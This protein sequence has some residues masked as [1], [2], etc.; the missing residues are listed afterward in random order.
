[1]NTCTAHDNLQSEQ[2]PK[3]N[4]YASITAKIVAA[5]EGGVRPWVRPWNA[6]LNGKARGVVCTSKR[7]CI[8]HQPYSTLFHEHLFG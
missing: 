5:L 3:Q 1:M 4:V 8:V 7:P 6:Q 2:S